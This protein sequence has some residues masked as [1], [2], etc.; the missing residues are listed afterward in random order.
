M[1]MKHPYIF[2]HHHYYHTLKSQIGGGIPFYSG[3]RQSGGGFGGVLS[4]FSK[5]AIP[6]FS[7]Y[8][9][10]H[11]RE[12][13]VNTVSDVAQNRSNLKQSIKSNSKSFINKVGQ[14]IFKNLSP[15]GEGRKPVKR[16]T[17]SSP[18][19]NK[20]LK[21]SKKIKTNKKAHCKKLKSS[22]ID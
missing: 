19:K 18:K 3:I 1:I 10:P 5:Y 22:K 15:K 2:H 17:K 16:K 12:A 9:L 20:K 21:I 13:L 8:I 7:K 11:A 6:L 14:N 4:F